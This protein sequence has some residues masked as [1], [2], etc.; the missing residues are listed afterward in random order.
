MAVWTVLKVGGSLRGA[1]LSA[2]TSAIRWCQQNGR[3]VAVVH[4]GGPRISAALQAAGIDLPFV[5]GERVTT[6]VGMAIV[7]RVLG[8]EVNSELTTSLRGAGIDA[9]GVNGADG[10]VFASPLPGK[11]RTARVSGV[12]A[13]HIEQRS[14]AGQVPVIAPLGCAGDGL[15]YNINADL[16]AA[17]IA[18]A[19]GAE[20]VVFLTDVPGIYENFAARRLITDTSTQELRRLQD[21]GRFHAGMIPKVN[22]LL[23]A[24]T[25]GVESAYVVDGTDSTALQWAVGAPVTG[26]SPKRDFGTCVRAAAAG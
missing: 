25:A 1:G 8:I 4:G 3:R 15:A 22:A 20:R 16:A 21:A 24:L 14:G 18:G 10:I 19:L 6:P 7:A 2:L 23:G 13:R 11:G 5:D 17:A 9:V 26:L 12:D